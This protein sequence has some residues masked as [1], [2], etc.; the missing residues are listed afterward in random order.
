MIAPIM[1]LVVTVMIIWLIKI[2]SKVGELHDRIKRLESNEENYVICEASKCLVNKN[3]AFIVTEKHSCT[4]WGWSY[5][6]CLPRYSDERK[7]YFSPKFAPNYDYVDMT[8]DHESE[9]KYYQTVKES[10]VE[11]KKP[12]C[13]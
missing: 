10:R 9:W 3:L 11:I 8:S 4:D 12:I 2:G 6:G 1:A 5:S 13:K 7:K